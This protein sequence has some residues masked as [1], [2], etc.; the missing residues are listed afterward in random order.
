MRRGPIKRNSPE[1]V[2]MKNS[3]KCGSSP[4]VVVGLYDDEDVK[5]ATEAQM[6]PPPPPKWMTREAKKIWREKVAKYVRR[7]Q[8]ITGFEASLAQF[9]ELEAKLI[10][11]WSS[12]EY[13]ANGDINQHRIFCCEFY[14]TPASRKVRV[15]DVARAGGKFA[16]RGA[17]KTAVR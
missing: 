8:P 13:P 7:N 10:K 16:G 3:Q 2:A 11:K 14:E 5:T 17:A 12:G 15:E 1:Q 9:C 4:G 6:P